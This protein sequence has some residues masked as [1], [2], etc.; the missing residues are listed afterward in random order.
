MKEPT[1]EWGLDQGR[2]QGEANPANE[3]RDGGPSFPQ[4]DSMGS[5]IFPREV[6]QQDFGIPFVPI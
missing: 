4:Q 1:D 3:L 6:L 5:S 2:E